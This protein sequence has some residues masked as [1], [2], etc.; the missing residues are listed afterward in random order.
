[1]RQ[2]QS[3]LFLIIALVS[4]TIFQLANAQNTESELGKKR[5]AQLTFITPIGSNG[6]YAGEITNNF[7]INML[8]GL[9]GGVQGF[10]L[11]GLHN[12]TKGDVR[13]VQLA[14]LGNV[15]TGVVNGLQIGGLYNVDVNLTKGLIAAGIANVVTGPSAGA[16]FAG[17]TNVTLRESWS[18]QASGISNVSV[19]GNH[20]M[21]IAGISNYNGKE[22]EGA[23]L[24]GI[25]NVNLAEHNSFQLAGIANV[26]INTT[27]GTQIAGIA[28]YTKK[29]N[30]FQ[31]GLINIADTVERG[32]P[33]GL[34]SIVKHGY[35]AFEL[36]AND[37]FWINGTYKM[38][39]PKL[40]NIFTLGFNRQNGQEMWAVGLGLGSLLPVGKHWGFNIDL[41]ASHVNENEWW[42]ED[43][44]LLN[45]LKWNAWVDLGPLQLF[46]GASINVY[47]SNLTDDEG[48]PGGNLID[49][50]L[51]FYKAI[52]GRTLTNVYPGFNFG[53][54]F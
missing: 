20:G 16:H 19:E 2:Q 3:R 44:N 25:A 32:V 18:F 1:M 5:I 31:L 38:G 4:V 10:E 45:R 35:Y 54:R 52:H 23:Q 36:E 41:T 15:S 43:L 37:A 29:L 21:Q 9:S 34:F 49:P 22:S 53:L 30:G 11:G 8:I 12:T 48:N 6:L 14:G 27:K 47:V 28:N 46:G 17:I 24:A 40:Y 51:S 26:A 13:G 39:V 42:T 50:N 33:L 7:S